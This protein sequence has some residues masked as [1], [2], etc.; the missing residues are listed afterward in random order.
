MNT[1]VSA[2]GHTLHLHLEALN[3]LVVQDEADDRGG[4]GPALVGVVGQV[5]LQAPGVVR[6]PISISDCRAIG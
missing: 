4:V 6:Q 3:V 1:Y 2:A 5:T